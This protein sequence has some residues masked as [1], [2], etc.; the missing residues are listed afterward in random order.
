[1]LSRQ[2]EPHYR[3]TNELQEIESTDRSTAG[4]DHSDRET[5]LPGTISNVVCNWSSAP[6]LE[7]S[8]G[9]TEDYV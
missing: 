9:R 4:R 3:V 8:N 1:M 5:W 2:F 6:M 7:A